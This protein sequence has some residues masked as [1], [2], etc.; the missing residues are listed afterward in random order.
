[1]KFDDLIFL[2]CHQMEK[3]TS[4]SLVS[5]LLMMCFKG[6]VLIIYD[7]S[8]LLCIVVYV[9]SQLKSFNQALPL[10]P[11]QFFFFNSSPAVLCSVCFSPFWIKHPSN[12][13]R[14]Y[15]KTGYIEFK[16]KL[17]WK[18]INWISTQIHSSQLF[19]FFPPHSLLSAP[20]AFEEDCT[21]V[22]LWLWMLELSVDRVAKV[23]SVVLC[24]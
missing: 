14:Q 13:K 16:R 18:L 20:S 1:M 21:H 17:N 12:F 6:I 3:F 23:H 11:Y 4:G 7:I 10:L 24:L 15:I 2:I 9:N 5:N 19:C 8:L 22:D